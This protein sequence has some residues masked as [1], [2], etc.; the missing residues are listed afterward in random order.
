MNEVSNK[1]HQSPRQ[2]S[3]L[4][5]YFFCLLRLSTQM[6]LYSFILNPS[7]IETDL[8]A[9][10]NEDNGRIKGIS[11]KLPLMSN[12]GQMVLDYDDV[13]STNQYQKI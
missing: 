4:T 10:T 1:F 11:G 9:N 12:T 8:R 2:F 7:L 3:K 5:N 13:S 6:H